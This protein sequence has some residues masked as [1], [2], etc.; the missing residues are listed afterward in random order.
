[1][2]AKETVENRCRTEK[3]LSV[4]R[5]GSFA[6]ESGTVGTVIG[7]F[8]VIG[9][10]IFGHVLKVSRVI[11]LQH[12]EGARRIQRVFATGVVDIRRGRR[13]AALLDVFPHDDVLRGR[14]VLLIVIEQIQ[15]EQ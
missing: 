10:Q 13:A 9:E 11:L 8:L 6:I 12:N 14:H 4:Q 1:M 2:I 5:G 15:V 3:H 7:C